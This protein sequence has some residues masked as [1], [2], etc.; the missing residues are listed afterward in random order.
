M[1][2]QDPPIYAYDDED[3]ADIRH[4]SNQVPIV[5][6]PG[7]T[8]IPVNPPTNREKDFAV[9]QAIRQKEPKDQYQKIDWLGSSYSG[10]DIKVVVH[11]YTSPEELNNLNSD[12]DQDK[13]KIIE[14]LAARRI[15]QTEYEQMYG[16]ILQLEKDR[17]A[18]DTETK[19][20]FEGSNTL[21]LATLQTL[22]VQSHREKFPV[23]GLGTS[24]VKAYTR[25]PRTI[26]GSMI[27]TTFNEHALTQLIRAMEAGKYY[28]E[29]L[30]DTEIS[31][32]I[33]DQIPPIDCTIVFANEYG[34][35]SRMG[36]YGLEFVND[37][38]TF[39]IEDLL[40]EGVMQFVA[41]DIDIMTAVGSRKLSEMEKGLYNQA[42]QP[43]TASSLFISNR[44]QYQSYLD[45]VGIQ[46]K[47]KGR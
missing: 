9:Q 27:F 6:P 30:L 17:I 15:S 40:T 3:L 36:I 42:G 11:M 10:A 23:R 12:L 46:R 47:Y 18:P 31:S 44:D 33:P 32:L 8:K 25:G 29:S 2:Y 37:G 5:G 1:S 22:S 35:V 7:T 41:R 43:V 34:S 39:S 21:V 14:D 26:A 38:T 16:T 24:Y 4:F 13:D 45:K 28:G 19:N 20:Q